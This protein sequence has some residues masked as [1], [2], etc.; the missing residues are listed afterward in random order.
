MTS[1]SVAAP[2]TKDSTVRRVTVSNDDGDVHLESSGAGSEIVL[3]SQKVRVDGDVYCYDGDVGISQRVDGLTPPKCM[4]PGGDKLRFDGTNWLCVCVDNWSG[5]TCE[6][7]PSPPPSP[8]PPP[9]YVTPPPAPPNPPPSPPPDPASP[10]ELLR[11]AV[12]ACI[13]RSSSGACTCTYDDPCGYVTDG[14]NISDFDTS[15]VTDMR[16]LFKEK[17]GFNQDLSRWNTSAVTSME[18]MFYNARAFNGAI[19]SWDVS[20]VT[21]M[22]YMFYDYYSWASRFNQPIGS[23]DVSN[24]KDMSYMF[25]GA[26]SFNQDLNNWNVSAVTK[27]ENMFDYAQRFNGDVTSWDVRGAS[28][29]HEMF[30][31]ASAF[32]RDIRSWDV[33][34]DVST[35]AMFDYT[36][37]VQSFKCPNDR[38]GPPSACYVTPFSSSVALEQAVDACFEEAFDGSCQCLDKCGEAGLPIS[39]WNTTGLLNMHDLFA[40]REFFNEDLSKWDTSRAIRMDDMFRNAK[41]FNRDISSWVVDSVRD[42]SNM[43]NGATTFSRNL[44]SWRIASGA[45][46]TDMFKGATAH[47]ARFTCD[48]ANDGPP[49]SCAATAYPSSLAHRFDFSETVETSGDVVTS[50]ADATGKAT[51]VQVVGSPTYA[52]HV[53]AGLNAINFTANGQYLQFTADGGSEP[54]VFIVYRV[55]AYAE[56]GVIFTHATGSTGSYGFGT[57]Q[58]GAANKIGLSA[59]DGSAFASVNASYDAWHVADV[60]FGSSDGFVDID[61]GTSAVDFQTSGKYTA[62]TLTNVM[63]GGAAFDGHHV[64]NLIGEVLVFNAKL[65][66]ADRARVRAALMSKWDVPTPD[67]RWRYVQRA[68]MTASD[69]GSSDY[70]GQSVSVSGDTVVVGALYDDDNGQSNSGSAYVFTRASD[71]TWTQQA[72]LTASDPGSS[73]YFGQSVSVSGDTVVVGAYYDDDSGQSNSGS[74]YVF[75]RASDGTWTQQA[76]LTASDAG[77]YDYFGKSVSISG[78]T[79]VIGAHHDDDNSQSDSGSAY[80]FT[81]ASDGTWT[82]QAK[83]TA[84]DAGSSDYFGSSVSVSGD[85]V[86]VGAH[87]DDDNSQSDSGSAYVFT[88]ASD[89]TWTQQAKLTASDAGSSDNFGSSVSVS[90]DTVVV[91]A[92]NDDDNSQSDSGSAYVFTR[93][94]DG[95]WTQQAKLTASDAGLYDYFGKSVSISGD[96]IV[97]G[98]HHDDDNSQSDSGSAY[99]FTRFGTTWM[100]TNKLSAASDAGSNDYFGSAVGI[101][102][103]TRSSS[104][105]TRRIEIARRQTRVRRTRSHSRHPE[106]T[107]SDTNDA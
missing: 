42:M 45:N 1:T 7:P 80:V 106:T 17:E 100:R 70:F 26:Y 40:D 99:V 25:R 30:W 50:F 94:S 87:H 3:K 58:M 74:A 15:Y 6:T 28:S 37:F 107:A 83:L 41:A 96:T 55:L 65:S 91:G 23:W 102:D 19:G 51:D 24:V 64:P 97:I 22:S 38:D 93:A 60:Y 2:V 85:T 90:G 39:S 35:Y 86:V 31:Y 4:P 66:D 57:S 47:N 84:S 63:I 88:R 76:K 16:E 104:A 72:K 21:D 8:S 52:R 9:P 33:S 48:D 78:D 81:R 13:A 20:S 103:G 12:A 53:Q 46:L 49:S 71:G 10:N 69:P 56:L 79:I 5:T 59:S 98:A 32:N 14:R 68:K 36:R 34:S 101:S 11:L 54:E 105:R 44:T 61:N 89:G 77:L 27:F 75:T 29:M 67:R 95:T 82:Q 62:N 43:F 18:R 73:D 92:L